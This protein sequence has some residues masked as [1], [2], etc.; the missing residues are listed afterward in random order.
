MIAYIFFPVCFS[1][2]YVKD[3]SNGKTVCELDKQ[4]TCDIVFSAKNTYMAAWQAFFTTPQN[5]QGDN[6]YE[7]YKISTGEVKKSIIHKRQPGWYVNQ[8]YF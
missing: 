1:R 2:L 8:S 7:I 4:R 6:N 5:P 3:V